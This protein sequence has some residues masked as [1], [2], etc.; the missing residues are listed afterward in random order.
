V[1]V[2]LCEKRESR[3][4]SVCGDVWQGEREQVC[5]TESGGKAGG[6]TSPFATRSSSMRAVAET[7]SSFVLSSS[8]ASCGAECH[9]F[10]KR[11]LVHSHPL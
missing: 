4:V 8:S 9:L 5:A 6:C 7:F 3:C 1:R 10:C 2:R 11:H